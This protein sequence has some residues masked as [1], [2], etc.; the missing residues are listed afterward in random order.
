MSFTQ[1]LFPSAYKKPTGYKKPTALDY[2]Y[3]ESPLLNDGLLRVSS[4]HSVYYREYGN[5][6]GEPVFFVHGGPGGGCNAN[7][8]RYFDPKK[9]RIILM[10]QRG[11]GKSIPFA[12]LEE[13]NTDELVKDINKLRD[14]LK[15]KEKMHVFGGSWGSTLSLVYAIR[16]PE[17][18]K[19]LTLRGIFFGSDLDFFWQG[20]AADPGNSK[21]QGTNR[22]YP[23]FWDQFIEFIPKEERGDMV[24][25][26]NKRLFCKMP[27]LTE[28]ESKALQL[29]A[30]QRWSVWEASTSKLEVDFDFIKGYNDPKKALPFARIENHYFTNDCFLPKDYII[31]NL[32]KIKDIPTSM[33]HGRYDWVC[34][35]EWAT[36]LHKKLNE[37]GNKDVEIVR[38]VAGHSAYEPENTKNL[39]RIMDERVKGRHEQNTKSATE[40]SVSR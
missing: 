20:D 6:Q 12:E 29:E 31:N 18:T 24:A 32:D 38:T 4:L 22:A 35:P 26:Y 16:H 23:E 2:L 14:H 9:Y 30:A 5:P 3:P 25:A 39:V 8:Y 1:K 34:L 33:V 11:C 15:I 10:D 21:L 27:G 37:A 13:N 17:N 19:S 40:T 7:D 36:Q 28:V